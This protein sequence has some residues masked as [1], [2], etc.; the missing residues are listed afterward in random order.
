MAYQNV[1]APRLYI[2]ELTWLKSMG[3]NI[4]ISTSSATWELNSGDM[5]K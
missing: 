1:G 3:V 5:Y 2:N 4:T